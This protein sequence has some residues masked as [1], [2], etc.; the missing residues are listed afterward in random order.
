M[1]DNDSVAAR[2][3]N[4]ALLSQEMKHFS[5]NLDPTVTSRL[6]EGNAKDLSTLIA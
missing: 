1:K 3:A 4:W 5:I 2:K 6:V